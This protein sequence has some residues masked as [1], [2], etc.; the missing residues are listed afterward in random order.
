M[1]VVN[2]ERFYTT[3]IFPTFILLF[4]LITILWDGDFNFLLEVQSG[5]VISLKS[6]SK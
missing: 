2:I 1:T 3:E 5:W 4:S 6:Q